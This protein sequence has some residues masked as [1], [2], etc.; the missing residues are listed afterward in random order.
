MRKYKETGVLNHVNAHQG[1]YM[2]YPDSIDYHEAQNIIAEAASMFETVP[3]HIRADFQNDPAKFLDF[4]QNPDNTQAIHDYGLSTT[5]FDPNE[6]KP[7]PKEK[8]KSKAKDAEK[9]S[10]MPLDDK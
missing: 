6:E 4:M 2:E 9:Q 3:S 10:E 5:H 7:K 8:P 1:T